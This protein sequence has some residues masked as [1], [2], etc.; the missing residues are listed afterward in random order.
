MVTIRLCI[1]CAQIKDVASSEKALSELD[2]IDITPELLRVSLIA[3]LR[4]DACSCNPQTSRVAGR[5]ND[6]RREVCLRSDVLL[7]I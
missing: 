1:L 3:L 7:C 2:A 5:L 6:F 4:D